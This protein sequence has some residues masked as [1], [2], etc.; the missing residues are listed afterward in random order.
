ML[1][2]LDHQRTQRA[3]LIRPVAVILLQGIEEL[4]RPHAALAH[5]AEQEIVFLGMMGV[6]DEMLEVVEYGVEKARVDWRARFDL[7]GHMV[8]RRRQAPEVAVVFADDAQCLH[9]RVPG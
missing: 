4:R 6:V 9:G 7:V 8:D 5:D 3:E 1:T 2:G